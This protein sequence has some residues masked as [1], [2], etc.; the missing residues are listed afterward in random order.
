MEPFERFGDEQAGI[1]ILVARIGVRERVADVAEAGSAEK[2]VSE[3][4]EHNVGVAMADEAARVVDLDAA[5]DERAAWAEAVRVMTD[6]NAKHGLH[7]TNEP[8]TK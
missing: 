2:G 4:V 6:A 7:P 8:R 3:C 5:E 1:A